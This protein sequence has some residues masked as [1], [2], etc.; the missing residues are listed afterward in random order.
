VAGR[1]KSLEIQQARTVQ[2]CVEI[3]G[4]CDVVAILFQPLDQVHVPK[5]P[6]E[7]S[8]AAIISVGTI[9]RNLRSARSSSDSRRAK[10]VVII[11]TLACPIVIGPVVVCLKRIHTQLVEQ[12]GGAGI[13]SNY[14]H[15]VVL[16]TCSVG[17]DGDKYS[18]S[19]G[20]RHRERETWAPGANNRPQGGICRACCLLRS[21][22]SV[23][24]LHQP[25]AGAPIPSE[26]IDVNR[27]G[28]GWINRYKQCDALS[29]VNARR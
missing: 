6:I 3:G 22:Q 16:K 7:E 20:I 13:V 10:A 11:K 21:L 12:I 23:N 4:I 28:L 2:V 19:P 14:K 17:Q 15:N 27:K 29:F 5:L 18:A 8:A 26:A 25:A 1:D 9:E 24:V